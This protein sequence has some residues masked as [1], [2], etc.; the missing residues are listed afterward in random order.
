MIRQPPQD[1][2][3]GEGGLSVRAHLTAVVA[4]L[5]LVLIGVGAY[6]SRNDFGAARR[7]ARLDTTFQARLAAGALATSLQQARA[8][9]IA[10]AAGPAISQLFDTIDGRYASCSLSGGGTGVFDEGSVH[11]LDDRGFLFCSSVQDRADRLG[12]RYGVLPWF[13]SAMKLPSGQALTVEPAEDLASGSTSVSFASPVKSASGNSLGLVVYALPVDGLG[14]TIERTYGGPSHMSFTISNE[15]TGLISS[16]EGAVSRSPGLRFDVRRPPEGSV[17]GL[18]GTRRLYSSAPAGRTGFSVT[19]GVSEALT[20]AQTRKD[21]R[22]HLLLTIL[23]LAVTLVLGLLINRRLGRPLR[24]L[25]AEVELAGRA[26]TPEPVAVDGPREVRQL[27]AHFNAMIATQSDSAEQLRQRV[28]YD[29]LT[30]LPSRVVAIDRLTHALDR[31]RRWNDYV[32]LL[33]IDLD[34]FS[35]VNESLGRDAGDRILIEVAA[36]IRSVVR[37]ADSVVRFY[38]D[39]F[40]VICEGVASPEEAGAVAQRIASSMRAPFREQ[41][42]ETRISASIGVALGRYQRDTAE[43][44]L[45]DADVARAAAKERG[46]GR[47]EFFH[48]SMR[49]R[50]RSRLELENDLRRAV[51]GEE[52]EVVYQAVVDLGTSRVAGAEALLRWAHPTKG[53]LLP[54]VFIGLAEET[55]LIVPIGKRVLSQACRQ[56]V[57]WSRQGHPI[58]VSVNL[59]AR[60]VAE[61][62]FSEDV[63]AILEQSGLDPSLLC[64]EVTETTLM[65]EDAARE[66]LERLRSLGVSISVDDFGTGYSSLAYL[67]RFPIDELKVDR[68]FVK[69]LDEGPSASAL[70][71]AIVG[72]A[73]ALNLN[74]VAE[75]VE[76]GSQLELVRSLGCNAAQGFLLMRPQ[77]PSALTAL[78]ELDAISLPASTP[79]AKA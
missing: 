1:A 65:R 16:S 57:D 70:I 12:L 76:T 29:A 9:A 66:T 40:V 68:A 2:S 53:T 32:G 77:P 19:A 17:P 23:A 41:D 43:T 47:H 5:A 33:S 44:L 28:L 3:P 13:A 61:P 62:E 26:L 45:R 21:L 72:M 73:R 6:Q 7:Q 49:E 78:L 36:R 42:L 48:S 24:K 52:L 55:G 37:P 67:Q 35:I 64:L 38:G 22:G 18:D 10:T 79:S 75:G 60:Q 59:S 74:V 51:E 14:K 15:A 46:K 54:G 69:A 11:F 34:R 4:A 25:T 71:A 50:A 20:L 27:V 56:G 39:E 58:R 30:G 63:R 31:T 8:A